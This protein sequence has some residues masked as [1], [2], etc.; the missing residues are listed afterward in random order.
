MHVRVVSVLVVGLLSALS[1]PVTLA[2][3][4]P[5][6]EVAFER[7][8]SLAG[9]WEYAEKGK[10]TKRVATYVVTGGGNVVLELMGGMS[11]AYHLDHGTLMLTH[12]CGAG[13]QPRMRVNSIEDGGRH[14]RFDFY[15]I[16]NLANQE[17]YRSTSLDVVFHEDGHVDLAYGGMTAG[18][19]STQ[20]FQ[21][22][23]RTSTPTTLQ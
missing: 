11:T 17:S 4:K 18:R 13:N 3:E 19:A 5:S 10:T 14:I 23:R 2:D 20:T 9:T 22:L 12:Y 15:D 6:S 1:S 21:L 8:K 16:T 7:L